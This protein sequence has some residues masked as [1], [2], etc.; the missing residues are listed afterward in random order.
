MAVRPGEVQR[1]APLWRGFFLR[2]I[3]A[4]NRQIVSHARRHFALFLSLGKRLFF[5]LVPEPSIWPK[6]SPAACQS[7]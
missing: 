5:G 7:R 2:R 3:R 4:S 1:K 6:G